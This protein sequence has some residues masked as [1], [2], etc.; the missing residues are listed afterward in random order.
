M[1]TNTIDDAEKGIPDQYP[2]AV[3]FPVVHSAS[4]VRAAD[5]LASLPALEIVSSPKFPLEK[6]S[7]NP[8]RATSRVVLSIPPK[9][10]LKKRARRWVRFQLWFNTYRYVYFKS[11][12]HI[13]R[14]D[15]SP[16]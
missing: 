7:P 16:L 8:P 15:I 6:V 2:V 5:T 12:P 1:S 10:A 14:L 11:G 4:S 3:S 13:G 9:K